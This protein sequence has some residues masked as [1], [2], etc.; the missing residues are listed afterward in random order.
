[1]AKNALYIAYHCMYCKTDGKKKIIEKRIVDD[2]KECRKAVSTF[3]KAGCKSCG[4]TLV[5]DKGYFCFGLAGDGEMDRFVRDMDKERFSIEEKY[6]KEAQKCLSALEKKHTIKESEVTNNVLIDKNNLVKYLETCLTAEAYVHSLR[7]ELIILLRDKSYVHRVVK[8]D[9]EEFEPIFKMFLGIYND[10]IRNVGNTITDVKKEI[11]QID[12]NII[13]DRLGIKKP[14]E[15]ICPEEPVRINIMMG[16]ELKEPAID[17]EIV[18]IY[19]RAEKWYRETQ[20]V[21]EP[22]PPVE[23]V[24]KK[25]GL[26]NK[27]KVD[28]ENEA[29]QSN[30]YLQRRKYEED[31]RRFVDY[32]NMEDYYNKAYYDYNMA[33]N[34]YDT[35]VGEYNRKLEELRDKQEIIDKQYYSDMQ[36]YQE[37]LLRYEDLKKEYDR[38]R[39]EFDSKVNEDVASET[40]RLTNRLKSLETQKKSLEKSKKIFYESKED[41]NVHMLEGL[42]S[43]SLEKHFDQRINDTKEQLEEAIKTKNQ[44]YSYGI[45]YPKYRD[46]VTIATLLEYIKS[47]RCMELEGKDGAYNIFEQEKRLDSIV[48]KLDVIIDSLEVIKNNQYTLYC[49]LK[50]TNKMLSDIDKKMDEEIRLLETISYNSENVGNE[51]I[52]EMKKSNKMMGKQNEMTSHIEADISDLKD[53]AHITAGASV[54]TA[55]NSYYTAQNTAATAYYAELTAKYSAITA[56]N[57]E[58]L[59]GL[60]NSLGYLIALK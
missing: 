4:R 25:A 53:T 29:L 47:G 39:E 43:Y 57:S 35:E 41:F 40:E 11:K 6:S 17:E 12:E 24:Y 1:M 26:L 21:F 9:K 55:I 45:V 16:E 14:Q 15:P 20:R 36:K 56:K 44:I 19:E 18:E 13:A 60:T 28:L 37:E 8:I 46:L 58:K 2:E 27:K 3:K 52:E 34:V 48:T 31:Y 42:K 10:E 5:G 7:E 51:I 38:E 59:V 49:E 33:K 50:K 22:V 32:R 23:P 30:Y 54:M